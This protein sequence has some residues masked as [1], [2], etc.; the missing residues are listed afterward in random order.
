MNSK[1]L[2]MALDLINIESNLIFQIKEKLIYTDSISLFKQACEKRKKTLG[3]SLYVRGSLEYSNKCDNFCKFCGMT[4]YNKNLKRYEILFEDAVQAIENLIA[5]N[6]KQLH[7]VGGETHLISWN[8]IYKIIDYAAKMGVSVTVVLGEQSETVYRKL[9]ESGAS[10]YI[11]KFETSN[12]QYYHLYKSNKDLL[13]RFSHLFLLRDIGFKIGSG[14][15]VGLPKITMD[16]LSKDI[17]ILTRL[18]PEMVSASAFQPNAASDLRNHLAGDI[19][20]TLK[21]IALYRL[22]IPSNPMISCSSGLGVDGQ[23]KCL[24]AGANV[25][26]VHITPTKFIDSFSMYQDSNRTTTDINTLVRLAK[27]TNLKLSEYT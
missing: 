23:I 14:I 27:M 24:N 25:A 5:L 26:S 12:S 13:S 21:V 4:K 15:I 8:T 2:S 22:L 7:I 9:F 20:L 11:L 16:D 19:E 3:D 10:R 18:K 17:A 1:Y 6:I